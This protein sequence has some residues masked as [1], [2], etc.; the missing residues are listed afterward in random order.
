[1]TKLPHPEKHPVKSCRGVSLKAGRQHRHASE[2]S[3]VSI[4]AGGPMITIC[5]RRPE[6]KRREAVTEAAAEAAEAGS[7]KRR[8]MR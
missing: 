5:A 7:N 1:M 3:T 2:D 6:V 4:N 8:W